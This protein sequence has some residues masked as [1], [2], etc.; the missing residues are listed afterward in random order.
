MNV[1]AVLFDF[2]FTLFYFEDVSLEKYMDCYKRGLQKS[3]DYLKKS[4]ILKDE[5]AVKE[6][7]KLFNNKR[8]YYFKQSRKTKREYPTSYIF[9]EV[10]NNLE[11]EVYQELSNLYH[12]CEEEEWKQ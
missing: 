8:S 1:K 12:S 6:F 5:V 4:D 3:V 7:F 10:L 11:K 9:Q 2:G